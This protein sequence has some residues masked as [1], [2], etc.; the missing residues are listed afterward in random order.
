M[1]DERFVKTPIPIILFLVGQT[2]TAIWWASSQTAQLGFVVQQLTEVKATVA[3]IAAK[4]DPDPLQELRITR[5][6]NEVKALQ[7]KVK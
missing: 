1:A 3:G 7:E 4:S 6:E 2:V 5:L